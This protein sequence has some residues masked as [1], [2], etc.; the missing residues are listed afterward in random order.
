[1]SITS[2]EVLKAVIGNK[3]SIEEARFFLMEEAQSQ[4]DLIE[5]VVEELAL[6]NG[7]DSEYLWEA[8]DEISD[9]DLLQFAEDAKGYESPT[10]G[11]TAKGRKAAGGH[12]QAPVTTPPSKLKRGSK[13]WKRRKSFCARMGGMKKKNTSAK[14]A[15]DPNSRIN[16][17]LKKWNC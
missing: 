9:Q 5:S 14:T 2:E 3:I 6:L 10:G 17:A 8:L 13:A 7:L 16:L 1:M 11:L 4:F 15:K 12:L